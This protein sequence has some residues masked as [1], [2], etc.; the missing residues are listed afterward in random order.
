MEA[1]NPNKGLIAYLSRSNAKDISHLK[2]SLS[3]LDANFND[4]FKYPVLIFHEDFNEKLIEDIQN[5]T[6]S[7]LRFER[8][9]FE[10]PSFLNSKEISK[11]VYVND[12]AF[13]IGY[14]HMCRFMSGLIFQHSAVKDYQYLWRLDTDSFLLDKVDYDV[15]ELMKKNDYIYGYICIL[16]DEADAVAG[17]WET[18]KKYI[19]EKNIK[20]IVLNKFM[21][22][23][24]WDRSCYYTNFEIS[25]IDFW[26]SDEALSYFN[27]LDKTGGIYKHR[28][29]DAAIHLLTISM[30]VPE[31][32]VHKFSDI[33]Y[34]H[35][36]VINNYSKEI[37]KDNGNRLH[38]FIK[39]FMSPVLK[40]SRKLKKRSKLYRKLLETLLPIDW[41]RRLS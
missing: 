2:R 20:P 35:Q 11:I 37:D 13:P 10:I 36:G 5:G 31:N 19:E 39:R 12:Y 41:L 29:G 33:A 24:A 34:Q 7:N 40:L 1:K 3:L 25:K 6:H 15:F 28:W 27:Y 8:I 23:G 32:K 26:R 16:K 21:S 38:T 4:T 30:F 14:R 17:L 22:D 18:T 9:R